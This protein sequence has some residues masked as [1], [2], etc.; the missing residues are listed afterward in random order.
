M[1]FL[2]HPGFLLG[3]TASTLTLI[4]F[5]MKSMLPLRS[6]ALASN[7][8]FIAYGYLD[9]LWPVLVLHSCL[10]P[11]NTKRL[12]DIRRLTAE[13]RKATELSP[14]S[15]WLLPHMTRRNFK[16][17]E[18][19]FRKGDEADSMYYI[20]NG[21]VRIDGLD[22][23]LGSG[24]LIGE[25]GLFAPDRKRT[26]TIV[27]HTDG[28]LYFMTDEMMYRLYYQNPKLGFFFMRLIVGRLQ[29]DIARQHMAQAVG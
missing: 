20:A 9:S 27:C 4:S 28:E 14:A 8:F 24:E 23:A 21:E 25:I 7:F 3:A 18:V 16:A 22:Q 11:L 6:F 12:L 2:S 13:I 1:E 5:S 10:L 17:G 26:Q 29:R 15:Q 19:L